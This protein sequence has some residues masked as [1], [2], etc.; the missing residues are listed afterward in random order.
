MQTQIRCEKKKPTKG[1]SW[2]G[3]KPTKAIWIQRDSDFGFSG[4]QFQN[5]YFKYNETIN[6]KYDT[7]ELT[8]R[9]FQQGNIK[10]QKWK[11]AHWKVK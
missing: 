1:Y 4:Q 5:S 2:S 11:L 9:E 8:N 10:Y 3:S 7:N 6:G